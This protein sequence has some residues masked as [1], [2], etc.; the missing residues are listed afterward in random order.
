MFQADDNSSPALMRLAGFY[1]GF[2][3]TSVGIIPGKQ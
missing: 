2:L 3:T 1:K